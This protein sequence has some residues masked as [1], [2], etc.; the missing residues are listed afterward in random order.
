MVKVCL[1]KKFVRPVQLPSGRY[2][3][4]H[5]K[6][7]TSQGFYLDAT[8]KQNIDN[9][10]IPAVEA[11]WDCVNLVTGVEGSGKSTFVSTIA[12]YIDPT[13][14]IDRICFTVDQ[15]MEQI[16]TCPPRSAIIFD[17]AVMGMLAQDASTA[18]QIRL[19]KKYVTMRSKRLYSFILIPSIFL[20]R[21]YF[22]ILRTRNLIHCFSPDG[23]Q[24][25][26]FKFYGPDTKRRL[27]LRGAK[28]MDMMAERPDFMGRFTNTW[29]CFF[30]AN[31]YE[32]KKQRTVQ[33]L[34]KSDE[35]RDKVSVSVE[36]A[37]NERNVALLAA[38][39]FAQ[40]WYEL[41]SPHKASKKPMS[42]GL[43]SK[44]LLQKLQWKV[45]ASKVHSAVENAK[46]YLEEYWRLVAAGKKID[47][48]FG[49][50]SDVQVGG[51]VVK[52]EV[53]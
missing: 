48:A 36:R 26:F 38:F 10:M 52:D 16:D 28:E 40:A 35:V 27:F 32:E 7:R 14:T 51:E 8:L 21:R 20:L 2:D 23:I 6:A 53:V 18:L 1:D 13:I 34:S 46:G 12:Y 22:A 31:A 47:E 15:L 41:E 3:Y 42:T 17:E 4:T 19:V 25:G 24:R 37:K 9:Y 45:S 11:R 30:D 29:G 5:P 44:L 33:A 50:F 49:D 43:F 39:K